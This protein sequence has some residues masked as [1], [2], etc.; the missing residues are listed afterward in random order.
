MARYSPE[1]VPQLI[2]AY[3]EFV[4]ALTTGLITCPI[5]STKARLTD[6][7]QLRMFLLE[8]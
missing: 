6:S 1:L 2:T 4:A 7:S 3:N 5:A 8:V